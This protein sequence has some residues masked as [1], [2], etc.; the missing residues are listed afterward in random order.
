M[1]R[2]SLTGSIISSI[3]LIHGPYW[4]QIHWG[5]LVST[6]MLH[7]QDMPIALSPDDRTV[8]PDGVWSGSATLDSQGIRFFSLRPVMIQNLR[9]RAS[10]WRVVLIPRM[11]ILIFQNGYRIVSLL[12]NRNRTCTRRKEQ[13]GLDSSA[14]HPTGL[15]CK[16][17]I[18]GVVIRRMAATRR[19]GK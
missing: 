8:A 14:R 3:S 10:V 7:W 17:T 15:T 11:E 2:L 6:G 16:G 1:R 13:Y 18:I 19:P 4:H 9:I 5:H 12:S